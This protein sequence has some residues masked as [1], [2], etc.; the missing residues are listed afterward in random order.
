MEEGAEEEEI[1]RMRRKLK[2]DQRARMEGWGGGR[3]EGRK[4]RE[5]FR[6]VHTI[7]HGPFGGRW[8]GES[9]PGDATGRGCKSAA[10]MSVAVPRGKRERMRWLWEL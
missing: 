3:E 7:S 4:K 8:R 10:E 6:Q 5:A 1:K 9:N 2:G